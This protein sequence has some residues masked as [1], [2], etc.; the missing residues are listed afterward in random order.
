MAVRIIPILSLL[1]RQNYKNYAGIIKPN[2]IS[3][4]TFANTVTKHTLTEKWFFIS[5]LFFCSF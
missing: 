2:R 1:V 3:F 5:D 4:D